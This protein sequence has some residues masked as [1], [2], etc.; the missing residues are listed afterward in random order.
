[1]KSSNINKES[2]KKS[3][4]YQRLKS[5]TYSRNQLAQIEHNEVKIAY[6]YDYVLPSLSRQV[7]IHSESSGKRWVCFDESCELKTFSTKQVYIR[8]T[9]EKHG[10]RLPGDGDFL[11]S[12]TTVGCRVFLCS[13]CKS[14]YNR[15]EHLEQHYKSI[16]HQKRIETSNQTL[17]SGC[18]D[19]KRKQEY[20]IENESE[21]EN[22]IKD[23]ISKKV[24][25]QIQSDDEDPDL[26]NFLKNNTI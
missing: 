1:M 2:F 7:I 8:H 9:I 6:F 14:S 15:K 19:F 26:I 4:D 10:S 21:R 13:I 22:E 16:T 17:I 25:L 23:H 11:S 12:Q 18:N 3:I 5:S 24:K 20:L